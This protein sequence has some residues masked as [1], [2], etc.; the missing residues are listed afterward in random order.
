MQNEPK[1]QSTVDFTSANPNLFESVSKQDWWL[2]PWFLTWLK[3]AG[4]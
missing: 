2:A 1:E 4:H 3:L